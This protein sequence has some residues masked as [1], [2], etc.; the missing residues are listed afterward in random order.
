MGLDSRLR[1]TE[2]DVRHA[3][4]HLGLKI[5]DTSFILWPYEKGYSKERYTPNKVEYV[6]A[7]RAWFR[8]H[9]DES[10]VTTQEVYEEA[11]NWIHC[12]RQS[13]K[14]A[15]QFRKNLLDRTTHGRKP[16]RY[17]GGRDLNE[18]VRTLQSLETR[19]KGFCK[20]WVGA[21]MA[22]KKYENLL[23]ERI[24]Q[25]IEIVKSSLPASN[26]ESVNPVGNNDMNIYAKAFTLGY[27][28]PVTIITRDN[29]FQHLHWAYGRQRKLLHEAGLSAPP[30]PL[31][32]VIYGETNVRGLVRAHG[33]T[34]EIPMP[35]P[36]H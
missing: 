1:M 19:E 25:L 14:E 15:R 16:K 26:Q 18:T 4:G 27:L 32:V 23:N 35:R 9:A 31:Y 5:I 34:R 29:H 7:S 8:K 11:S 13:H 21:R 3:F 36:S 12:I 2:D 22:E 17:E 33:H 24:P 10:V 6:E 30:Y 28:G 20:S